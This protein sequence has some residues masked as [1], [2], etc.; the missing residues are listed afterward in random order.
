MFYVISQIDGKVL[1]TT[2]K[3]S[4]A[5]CQQYADEFNKPVYIIDGQHSGYEATPRSKYA[6][7]L[8]GAEDTPE[9]REEFALQQTP[10]MF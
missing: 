3:M 7:W 1:E 8:D 4:A 9:K 5:L 6:Q 2:D 10:R